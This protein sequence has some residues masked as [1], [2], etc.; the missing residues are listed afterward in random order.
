MTSLMNSDVPT[1]GIPL[2]L[3]FAALV[4]LIIGFIE[5]IPSE[6]IPDLM[7]FGLAIGFLAQEV[8]LVQILSRDANLKFQE[9]LLKGKTTPNN[10]AIV[11]FVPF[12]SLFVL[13]LLILLV[14]DR[15]FND[16]SILRVASVA[17]IITFG[18]DPL[19]GL[20]E[21]GLL[22]VFGASLVYFL[23]IHSGVNGY[24]ELAESLHGKVGRFPAMFFASSVLTYLLLSTRWT[25]YRLFCFNQFD[26]LA[27][28]LLDTGLP[29][30]IILLPSI[31]DFVKVLTW[32][33][34]GI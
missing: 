9:R 17:M 34:T 32:V 33:Y 18:L 7:I 24:V 11:L 6:L 22:A 29:L 2:N 4:G 13:G 23:I 27:R 1:S 26:D 28:V 19:L 25:Y 12:I 3:A 30:L 21:R 31:P 5:D 15:D 8:I 14:S 20:F 10:R 16:I